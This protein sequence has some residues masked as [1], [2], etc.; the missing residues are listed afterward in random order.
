MCHEKISFH[1]W[2]TGSVSCLHDMLFSGATTMDVTESEM[3]SQP[4]DLS[5]ESADF[6]QSAR[7]IVETASDAIITINQDSK[8]LFVN[9]AAEKIFGYTAREMLGQELTMLMPDYLRKLHR[10]GLKNYLETGQRHI[11]WDAVELPGRHKNGAEILL[12]LSFGEFIKHGNHFFTGVARDIT[13]RKRNEERLALQYDVTSIMARAQSVSEASPLLLEAI[14]VNLHCE[15]AELW[16]V[17]RDRNELRFT[18]SWHLPSANVAEFLE[19]SR[20]LT[21]PKGSGV[22]GRIWATKAPLWLNE[23]ELNEVSGRAE[24]A[25]R[26][27][28]LN[29]FGFPILLGQEILGVID[30]FSREIQQPSEPLWETI[31]AIGSQVGQ[32]IQRKRGEEERLSLLAREQDARR[33]A[34]AMTRQLAI[35]QR[36]TDAALVH[37]SIEDLLSELLASIREV[38]NVDTVA[39]LMMEE[40]G[41]ELVAWAARGLEEEVERGVRIPVG[42][43]FAGNVVATGKPI[44]IENTEQAE[45]HNPLLR[46]KGI[47]SLLGVPLWVQGRASG[48]LHVG[49]LKPARFTTDDVRLLQLFA[50]RIALP[51][52]NTRLFEK[53]RKARAEA[54]RVNRLKDEFLAILSHELRTP[55]TPIMGW[56]HMMQNGI[57]SED[58]FNKGLNSVSKN[59][60]RLKHLI[61]DLLDMSAVVSGKLRIEQTLVSLGDPLGEAVEMLRPFAI[62]SN[63]QLETAPLKETT[64]WIVRGDRERLLQVF[65]NLLHNAIKFSPSGSR[66][67]ISWETQANTAVIIIKDEGEGIEPEFLPHVF[68]RFR[69]ADGSRTR[70]HGGLGLG[71][72]LVKSFVEAHGGTVEAASAGAQKGSR[73]TVRLPLQP[74]YTSSSIAPK[75]QE[76][77]TVR[78]TR[79]VMIVEDQPDTLDMLVKTFQGGGFEVLSCPS[80]TEALELSQRTGFDL[81]ISDIAMPVM[82]GLSLIRTLRQR[83]DS[84]TLPAIA[85]TG[86]ASEADAKAALAAGF[87]VHIPKPVDP[88]EL[89]RAAEN[90]LSQIQN[91]P[92]RS[93]R[94]NH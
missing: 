30:L 13:K 80:A 40:E 21:F 61:S 56:L 25:S 67:N 4:E 8:I 59:S 69:Q 43:G 90:L 81:L 38:L 58:D 28:L 6:E 83:F 66:V 71:L 10:S 5:Q 68:E 44:I 39:I 34:E 76:T 46:E 35:V 16:L 1:Q 89:T 85:L 22:P 54:E 47:S 82:D 41:G 79:R 2:V 3:T 84:N 27:R 57:V 60:Y 53:E 74:A 18:A 24:V 29:V 32:Y 19:T 17:D 48:V 65:S 64:S 23:I 75:W 87:S 9:Q 92:N 7:I 51:I 49:T 31:N 94:Q 33:E 91:S 88:V 12:E 62:D 63:I 93:K 11:N 72:A 78:P 77:A 73:F 52:E 45:L 14:C 20:N 70:P 37:L 50:D 15:V 26:Q 55:L 42:Q 86:Y 36:V